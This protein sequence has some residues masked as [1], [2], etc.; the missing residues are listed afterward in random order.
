MVTGIDYENR[1]Y[2]RFDVE[3]GGV[4]QNLAGKLGLISK[5]PHLM[6][7]GSNFQAFVDWSFI[8]SGF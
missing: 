1:G 3:I 4:S 5:V 8:Q 7:F 6:E 2:P